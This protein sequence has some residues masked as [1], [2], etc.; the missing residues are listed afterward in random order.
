[1]TYYASEIAKSLGISK[2]TLR[3]YE[4]EGL[5]PSIERNSSGHRIYSEADME[6]IYLI[7]CLRDTDMPISKI[8]QYVSLLKNGGVSS[9]PERRE[10][11]SEHKGYIT[12]K[13]AIY[14]N[15]LKLIDKKIAFYNDALNTQNSEA[16]KCMD[17][18]DEWEHFKSIIGGDNHD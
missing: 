13:I 6:W 14:N 8:K 3:Y 10:I 4:K 9:I 2:D 17:Y 15:L 16:V 5:L 1:M 7:R 12:E 11:L 18:A